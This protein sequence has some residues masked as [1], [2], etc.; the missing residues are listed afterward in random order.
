MRVASF[1]LAS[2]TLSGPASAAGANQFDLICVS[3]YHDATF[4]YRVDLAAGKYCVT[5][6]QGKRWTSIGDQCFQDVL[7]VGSHALSFGVD[8]IQYVDRVTG[9]WSFKPFGDRYVMYRG[10]CTPAPFSG[11]PEVQT[12]F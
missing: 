12:K 5:Q 1:A 11:F 2:L 7:E 4:H 6:D 3:R 10:T 9:E 8:P